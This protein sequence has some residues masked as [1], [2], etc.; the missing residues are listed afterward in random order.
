MVE[1]IGGL[2]AESLGA[3]QILPAGPVRPENPRNDPLAAG[4]MNA[5]V[6]RGRKPW[7][8][9]EAARALADLDEMLSLARFLKE[10]AQGIPEQAGFAAFEDLWGPLAERLR[11]TA[12]TGIRAMVYYFGM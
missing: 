4:L 11:I 10:H 1:A 9:E 2:I 12:A 6:F 8:Q 3:K 7:T 5:W